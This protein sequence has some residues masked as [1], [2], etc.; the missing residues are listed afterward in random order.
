MSLTD[1]D[2]EPF[3]VKLR[4]RNDGTWDYLY[5]VDWPREIVPGVLRQIAD[6]IELGLDV[7]NPADLP[8]PGEQM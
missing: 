7:R 4:V 8:N 1:D 6:I 2:G 3:M 5:G